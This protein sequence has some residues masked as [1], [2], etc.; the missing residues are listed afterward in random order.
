MDYCETETFI[1]KEKSTNMLTLKYE[2]SDVLEMKSKLIQ[3]TSLLAISIHEEIRYFK[4]NACNPMIFFSFL[5]LDGIINLS[6]QL[7]DSKRIIY[8]TNLAFWHKLKKKK[9]LIMHDFFTKKLI[10]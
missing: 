10:N 1:A 2:M 5:T 3:Y 4:G 9:S 7:V 8:V 6:Q